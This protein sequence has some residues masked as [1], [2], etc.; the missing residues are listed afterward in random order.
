MQNRVQFREQFYRFLC[1]DFMFRAPTYCVDERTIQ[2]AL[3]QLQFKDEYE[4]GYVDLDQSC[5]WLSNVSALLMSAPMGVLGF[6]YKHGHVQSVFA[7]DRISEVFGYTKEQVVQLMLSC[8][9]VC[10]RACVCGETAGWGR[11][12]R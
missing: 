1:R 9:E 5:E 6:K 3:E 8:T 2:Q 12:G 11:E 4:K 10:A 7:N